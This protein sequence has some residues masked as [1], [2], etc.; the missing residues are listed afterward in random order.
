MREGLGNFSGM[1]I[2][3]NTYTSKSNLAPKI[4]YL[5]GAYILGNA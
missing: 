2:I 1:V 3:H 4:I 5:V